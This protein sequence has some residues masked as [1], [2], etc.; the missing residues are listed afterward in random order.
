MFSAAGIVTGAEKR[1]SIVKTGAFC[2][3][4]PISPVFC[5]TYYAPV[6]STVFSPSAETPREKNVVITMNRAISTEKIT[7]NLFF[8]V[9]SS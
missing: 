8:I 5:E 1:S 2:F 7:A 6:S 3:F 4:V 9:V